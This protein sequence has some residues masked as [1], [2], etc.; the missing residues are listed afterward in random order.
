ME[1][2][3]MPHRWKIAK[4]G[5]K[6]TR[7]TC[8]TRLRV[9]SW[10]MEHSSVIS[11]P[12]YYQWRLNL[13]LRPCTPLVHI[14][15]GHIRHCLDAQEMVRFGDGSRRGGGGG[16]VGRKQVVSLRLCTSDSS[17][18]SADKPTSMKNTSIPL[19]HTLHIVFPNKYWTVP[20]QIIRKKV[21]FL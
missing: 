7:K 21:I 10:V 16:W 15:T 14:S 13:S 6:K 5:D 20:V 8:R 12:C 4:L 17:R 1:K 3:H 19:K 18:H 9:V 2:W 11:C